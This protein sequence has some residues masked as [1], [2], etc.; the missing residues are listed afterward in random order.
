MECENV[1]EMRLSYKTSATIKIVALSSFVISCYWG[2][3]ASAPSVIKMFYALGIYIA[4]GVFPYRSF[5]KNDFSR[6]TNIIV[7]I[8]LFLGII[9][10]FRSVFMPPVNEVII[11]NKW[12]TLF[13]NEYTIFLFVPPLFV[14]LA[15][16]TSAPK[17]LMKTTKL[18]L[19]ASI[20][21]ILLLKLPMAILTVYLLVFY[22]YVNKRYKFLILLSIASAIIDGFVNS[23]MLFIIL[24][25]AFASYIMIYKLEYPM[26]TK[27][28]CVVFCVIPLILACSI[29]FSSIFEES[30]IKLVMDQVSSYNVEDSVSA[31]TRTF[32]YSEMSDDLTRTGSWLWG[33]GAYS[34]YYSDYFMWSSTG[35]GDHYERLICE[36][37]FLLFL[38]RS[39]GIY[40]IFYFSLLLIA[41]FKAI[42]SNNKF[43]KSIG[44]V[45]V[46]WYFNSFIGDI[47]GCRFYHLAFFL[48]VGVCLSRQW[49]EM[50]D[51]EIISLLK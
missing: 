37:P 28:F 18:Y 38:L 31:D 45:A 11:G 17:L 10:V 21:F 48:L 14:Y 50:N 6:A 12:T 51:S 20:P 3:F 22:P 49:R 46:G 25:F 40:V 24:F 34:H 47:N 26:L 44:V 9:Q 30:L 4:L 35:D 27:T 16:I 41:I 33:K 36:V 23:R 32:L 13:F 8:L 39:G 15:F 19:I 1:R 42:K 43:V 2:N 5:K 7:A 29:M